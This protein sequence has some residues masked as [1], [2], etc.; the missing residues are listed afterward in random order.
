MAISKFR[1]PDDSSDE[2]TARDKVKTIE[3]K[4]NISL[5]AQF[6]NVSWVGIQRSTYKPLQENI[7]SAVMVTD[8]V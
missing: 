2:S 1:Y 7:L 5:P 3:F 6:G 8:A 4:V